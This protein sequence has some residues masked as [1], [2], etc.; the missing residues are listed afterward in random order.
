MLWPR[1][2]PRLERKNRHY[3]KTQGWVLGA[4]LDEKWL[5][6][7]ITE[8]ART[9][10]VTAVTESSTCFRWAKDDAEPTCCDRGHNLDRNA[11]I[12]HYA[13]AQGRPPCTAPDGK[14]L[15][16]DITE[17][18]RIAAVAAATAATGGHKSNAMCV[19][20]NILGRW[21]AKCV[22]AC[23]RSVKI[24][25]IVST[26]FSYLLAENRNLLLEILYRLSP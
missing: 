16:R 2:Q 7:G 11:G 20:E 3:G 26:K 19:T 4:A 14:R 25:G 23:C 13:H 12:Q 1:P 15:T 24:F 8:L 5:T 6:R 22:E 18:A 10:A 17:L 21:C 9:G